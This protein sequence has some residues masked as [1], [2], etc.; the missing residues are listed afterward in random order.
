M[1]TDV[2]TDQELRSLAEDM[3]TV[4]AVLG[5]GLAD[6]LK[7]CPPSQCVDLLVATVK[8][9]SLERHAT[10]TLLPFYIALGNLLQRMER[11]ETNIF[12]QMP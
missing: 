4:F 9:R 10:E 12:L 6:L 7:E 2:L 1:V 3:N 5:V 8:R 11:T